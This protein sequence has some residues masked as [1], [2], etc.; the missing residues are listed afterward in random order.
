LNSMPLPF[1]F[2]IARN[3]AISLLPQRYHLYSFVIWRGR[4]SAIGATC[5]DSSFVRMTKLALIICD[6]RVLISTLISPPIPNL[7]KSV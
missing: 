6:G 7:S 2:V 3:D 4:N 5:R 1:V